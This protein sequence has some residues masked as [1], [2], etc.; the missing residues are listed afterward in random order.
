MSK[1]LVL[2][3]V[4]IVGRPSFTILHYSEP[5][6]LVQFYSHNKGLDHLFVREKIP[7][8]GLSKISSLSYLILGKQFLHGVKPIMGKLFYL[9]AY[10]L[11]F[12]PILIKINCFTYK[13]TA[14]KTWYVNFGEKIVIRPNSNEV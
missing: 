14:R 12:R 11:G 6:S 7:L 13:P 2:N 3:I 9:R 5:Y 8:I 10:A 4:L 1:V